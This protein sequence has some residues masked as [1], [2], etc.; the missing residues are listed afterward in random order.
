MISKRLAAITLIITAHSAEASC[1]PP[2]MLL[3]GNA[4]ADSG[5]ASGSRTSFAIMRMPDS[6]FPAAASL[7]LTVAF[8]RMRWP[9]LP[10][11]HK[12]IIQPTVTKT[13][14]TSGSDRSA[15]QLPATQ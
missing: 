8:N 11:R 4:V 3:Q 10:P 1:A 14:R 7:C 6:S 2:R 9:Y 5:A 13:A 15:P 12:T